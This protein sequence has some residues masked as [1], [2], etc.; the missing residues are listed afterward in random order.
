MSKLT[1]ALAAVA[2]ALVVVLAV[3]IAVVTRDTGDGAVTPEASH[4]AT[5]GVNQPSGQVPAATTSATATATVTAEA[6]SGRTPPDAAEITGTG[7]DLQQVR[8]IIQSPTG[9]IRCDIWEQRP[10]KMDCLVDRD[11]GSTTTV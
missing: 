7:S 11:D 3:V 8:W 1:G 2:A 5:P 6:G 4:V 10:E 9:T